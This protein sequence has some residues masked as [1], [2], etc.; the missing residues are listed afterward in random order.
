M[1][2]STT[3]IEQRFRQ[4]NRAMPEI[5]RR[6]AMVIEGADILPNDRGTAPGQWIEEAASVIVICCPGRRTN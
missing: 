4:M 1:P 5:N 2:R 3:A 6:Q